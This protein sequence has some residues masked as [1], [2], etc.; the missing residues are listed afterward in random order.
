MTGRVLGLL[1]ASAREAFAPHWLTAALCL[2]A[3]FANHAS[4]AADKGH[5]AAEQGFQLWIADHV[6]PE[7]KAAAVPRATF[8]SAM[9]G[10]TLDWSLPD[11]LLPGAAEKVPA[12]QSQAEFASPA[13]YFDEARL[14]RL[15]VDGRR[16]VEK[17]AGT[18]QAIERRYGVPRGIVVAIW[19]RESA[20]GSVPLT[21]DAVRTLAT[22]AYLGFR[23]DIFEPELIAALKILAR[24][25]V[26]RSELKSSWAG[27][28]GQPQ[29]LPSHFL[30]YAVDFEG[31]GKRDIW[32]S[33]P[34]SLASIAN[35]LAEQGW[36][37]GR[38]WGFEIEV[39]E[40]V[41]CA[42][43]GPEQGKTVGEW[44]RLGIRRVDGGA[45]P[46]GEANEVAYLVLPAGR[47][48]PA[49]LVSPNFY[50]LKTYNNSDL[51]ALFVGHVADRLVAD[52]PFVA[53]WEKI[54]GF[55]RRDVKAMQDR[56]VALGYDVGNADG[57]IGFKTRIAIGL[58][59]A[60]KG[61]PPTCFPRDAQA[62]RKIG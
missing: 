59:Q 56:L 52:R 62:I 53:H 13:A 26:D 41:S 1:R 36:K 46:A 10:V 33:V 19:G 32:H 47:L 60:R 17:W 55:S 29:L 21:R 51:Y 4:W 2:L 20:Y 61:V 9:R 44:T 22:E 16:E 28:L 58:W 57:L 31:N 45:F 49:Y 35:A 50:V 5:E 39:P 54:G 24:G 15:V 38:E 43:E 3:G 42:A 48:G 40:A 23:K 12:A 8:D 14:E 11:L 30:Q 7:A 25:D 34:D 37:R 6:W 27:A 18:L